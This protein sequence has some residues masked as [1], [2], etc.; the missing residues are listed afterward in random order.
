M[1]MTVLDVARLLCLTTQKTHT[2]LRAIWKREKAMR[3]CA[4]DFF[5]ILKNELLLDIFEESCYEKGFGLVLDKTGKPFL[6][7][8]AIKSIVPIKTASH[9]GHYPL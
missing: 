4:F 8:D 6:I 1:A 2:S 7:R 5:F 9:A 3:S